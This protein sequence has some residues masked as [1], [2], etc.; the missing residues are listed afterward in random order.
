MPRVHD[1][2]SF[3]KAQVDPLL[4]ISVQD[5]FQFHVPTVFTNRRQW[6]D[7]W[8]R[9]LLKLNCQDCLLLRLLPH[10]PIS[11]SSSWSLHSSNIH[12]LSL[13][14]AHILS[15]LDDYWI[16]FVGTGCRYK[17]FIILVALLSWLASLSGP[18]L[19]MKS[20]QISK[21][22]IKCRLISMKFRS[23]HHR[24]LKPDCETR[25]HFGE[26]KC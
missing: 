24:L 26:F 3:A 23:F 1:I 2:L 18:A 14:S 6:T 22:D 19:S 20:A 16:P 7:H 25:K 8:F 21:T 17:T 13:F 11:S 15:W 9:F 12:A 10:I 5:L 4:T